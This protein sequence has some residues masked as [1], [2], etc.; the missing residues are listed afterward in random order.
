M[1]EPS[2]APEPRI[3]A[4]PPSGESGRDVADEDFL[5][6]L[7]RGSEL[8]QDDRVHEAKEEL[9]HA[10]TFQPRDAKGQDLLGVVYFR[11]GLYPRAIQIY[12]TLRNQNPRE[13]SVRLNLGLC[14]LKSAQAGR[15]R[16]ELEA[17]V[18]SHPDHRRAWG[19][20]G[21]AYE[22]TGDLARAQG[23]FE[24]G[25]HTHMAKR[26]GQRGFST[27]RPSE[28]PRAPEDTR[29][30]QV[31]EVASAAFQELD[32]GELSFS[33]A[34]PSSAP[35]DTA[36][37]AVELGTLHP[38]SPPPAQASTLA[39]VTAAHG[40]EEIKA[41]APP[42]VPALRP[43]T[44][45]TPDTIP[46]VAPAKGASATARVVPRIADLTAA[47]R[48]PFSD[49]PGVVLSEG[50]SGMIALATTSDEA[51]FAARLEALRSYTGRLSTAVLDRQ[52]RAKGEPLGGI[53]AP[54]VRVAGAGQLVLAPRAGHT[55]VAFKV[56][57]DPAF[58][59]EDR[60]L[61]SP[62]LRARA[63]VRARQTRRHQRR[64]APRPG[65]DPRRGPRQGLGA[66]RDERAARHR[67]AR[68]HRGVD[69]PHHPARAHTGG[70][71]REPAR[72]P[73]A[74]GRGN[75]PPDVV[76]RTC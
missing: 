2:Q 62:R 67:A 22:R 48:L 76:R 69:R 60:L 33:L 35:P 32:A 20:L 18:K 57:A 16:D 8:L 49:A 43:Q 1:A 47:A 17:L 74:R 6:H 52:G 21:L 29:D 64:A 24:R 65:R 45:T 75:G 39:P 28:P 61:G 66:R 31:R 51:P 73:H 50:S 5:F 25:G 26:I 72:P 41:L 63:R 38:A 40:A 34:A 55:L 68:R 27:L 15:A 19:Y 58:V 7:Y 10:L 12:E 46:G 53:G 13:A 44:V 71:P 36:W 37:R 56:D 14:Y 11:L 3:T 30:E 54:I 23:A 59:H 4:P 42:C 9:E 70:G